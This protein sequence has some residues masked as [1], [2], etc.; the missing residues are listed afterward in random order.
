MCISAAPFLR[1]EDLRSPELHV[2][3]TDHAGSSLQIFAAKCDKNDKKLEVNGQ[4]APKND[5]NTMKTG[6]FLVNIE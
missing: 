6:V 5:E 2:L 1:A 4:K 3:S